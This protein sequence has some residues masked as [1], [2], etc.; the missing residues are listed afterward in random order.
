MFAR[1]RL[2]PLA[3]TALLGLTALPGCSGP[4]DD[5]DD[6]K[7]T[8]GGKGDGWD[9]QGSPERFGIPLE[10]SL[11]ALPQSGRAE[12]APWSETY[13]PTSEDSFN[14]R[15]AGPGTLSPLEKYDMAFNGW[16]PPAGFMSLRPMTQNNCASGSWDRA[17]YQGLGPAARWWS[18]NKGLGR[19]MNGS[20]DDGDGQKDECSDLDGIE[21]WWG[22]CHAWTPA[23][24]LE[25]EPLEPVTVNGVR[26]EVSD[27]KALVISLYEESNQI[28]IGDRCALSNPPRDTN[29]RIIDPAC[30]NTNAGTFHLL[31]TNLLGRDKRAFAEDRV[32]DSEV[33]NQPIIGYRLPVQKEVTLAQALALLGVAGDSYP[34]NP[35]AKRFV[36]VK[37]D[38]DYVVETHPSTK[39]TSPHINDFVRTDHYHYVLEL[40]EAG[41]IIGG[42]WLAAPSG[43]TFAQND[44]PDYL[45]LPLGPGAAP[46]PNIR[47][48][49]VRALLR[50]SRPD[51]RDQVVKS[52]SKDD[53][54]LIPD[55]P[56]AGL[57]STITV[58]D[59][60]TV[61][62]L[63][64]RAEIKHDWAFDVQIRLRHA[65]KEVLIFDR[66][67]I[68]SSTAI[69][70][71]WPVAEF[72]GTP[73][74]GDYTLV[75]TD[76]DSRSIGR[77]FTWSLEISGHS[78]TPTPTPTPTPTEPRELTLSSTG[79]P[80]PIP[81][82]NAAGVRSTITVADGGTAERVDVTVNVTHPYRGDLTVILEHGGAQE[83]L[84]QRLGGSA[85]DLRQTFT[86]HVF[87]GALAQGDWTMRVVDSAGQDVGQLDGWTLALRVR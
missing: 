76:R 7:G 55:F 1:H 73:A 58:P 78:A 3:L 62:N 24:I 59:T 69:V 84:V 80:L 16:V 86:A 83:I 46:N 63:V 10:Y 31:L 5:I 87:G 22:S 65:G 27:I 68:G 9:F 44:R 85:D 32:T 26:F 8:A 21:Y 37:A 50:Q 52:Y 79:A 66:R 56:W 54:R 38:I 57:E 29:G 13:W 30:R 70:G 81:D 39:P 61:K 45:W 74:Q 33:W 72:A 48:A 11:A 51:L 75:V 53:G 14:A 60:M 28:A 42:E 18:N 12:I 34:Y 35:K 49:D 77:L 17:Y 67:P 2:E 25:P 36:E 40:D 41:K 6:P 20:D 19:V 15:W 71:A 43:G 47:S 64:V 23:A 4:T 82:N